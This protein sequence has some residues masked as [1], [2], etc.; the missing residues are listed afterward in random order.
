MRADK[1][2]QIGT[3]TEALDAIEDGTVCRLSHDLHR[4]GDED[5]FIMDL[6]VAVNAGQIRNRCAVRGGRCKVWPAS[7]D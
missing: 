4:S 2:N 3:L 1:V 6:A 7:A 5:A